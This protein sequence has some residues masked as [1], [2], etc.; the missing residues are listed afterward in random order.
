MIFFELFQHGFHDFFD[1]DLAVAEFKSLGIRQR[2]LGRPHVE[3]SHF[4]GELESQG[5]GQGKHGPQDEQD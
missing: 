5:E 2:L 3:S 1:P 4:H